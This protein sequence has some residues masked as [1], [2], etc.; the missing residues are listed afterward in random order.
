MKK[1]R[2]I[3]FCLAAAL[4]AST[5]VQATDETAYNVMPNGTIVAPFG[6]N[7]SYG[8]WYDRDTVDPW[9]DADPTTPTPGGSAVPWG[10]VNGGTY[11]TGGIYNIAIA[12]HA[13]NATTATMFATINGIQQGFWT[14][15]YAT[16]APNIYPAGLSF[17]GDMTDLQVFSSFLWP[18]GRDTPGSIVF[19]DIAVKQNATTTP[20]GNDT[21]Q[22][23]ADGTV[24]GDR[25]RQYDGAWNLMMGDL[26]LSYQADFSDITSRLND[27]GT[28]LPYGW[29]G[30]LI[31]FGLQ[32]SG[33]DLTE[34]LG[35][36]WLGNFMVNPYPSPD[37]QGL[38]EKF[39]LQFNP[40]TP[41]PSVPEPA[42]LALLGLGLA[43]LAASRRRKPN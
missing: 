22:Y 41:Q 1:S 34:P 7:A 14:N 32:K 13:V 17:T 27:P 35:A 19:N 5:A 3:L 2:S 42:T 18:S 26:I 30:E 4:M 6:T 10:S 33:Q 29:S 21:Y 15:G 31:A 39:D 25:A 20:L 12:Y 40:N 9:Q 28:G 11:N 8:I 38:N 43:G 37:I 36:G 24:V 23:L 16:P